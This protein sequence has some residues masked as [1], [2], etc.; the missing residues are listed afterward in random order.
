MNSLILRKYEVSRTKIIRQTEWR[1]I[2][3][4]TMGSRGKKFESFRIFVDT[5]RS[6]SF[7][8]VLKRRRY[9]DRALVTA[10]QTISSMHKSIGSIPIVADASF[11]SQ[12]SPTEDKRLSRYAV[13]RKRGMPSFVLYLCHS[14][15]NKK[16]K[17]YATSGG[18]LALCATTTLLTLWCPFVSWMISLV[19]D[20]FVR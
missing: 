7:F 8:A 17:T 10:M 3:F 15:L 18:Y 2:K 1:K 11:S 5:P 20:T 12:C 9:W 14:L 19:W 13:K 6:I 4:P 16:R